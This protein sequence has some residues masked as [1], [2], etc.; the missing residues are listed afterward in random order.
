MTAAQTCTALTTHCI[1][2]IDEQY[3]RSMFFCLAEQVTHAAC[4]YA[5][6]HF[7]KVRTGY[8][9]EWYACLAG[10]RACKKRLTCSGRSYEQY[11]L[12]DLGPQFHEA[13]RVFQEFDYLGKLCLFF[14]GT[15]DIVKCD[16]VLFR[17]C[18]AGTALAETHD[19]LIAA[20]LLTHEEIPCTN[21]QY[22]SHYERYEFQPP[23][24]CCRSDYIDSERIIGR[25]YRIHILAQLFGIYRIDIGIECIRGRQLYINIVTRRECILG[26]LGAHK[27]RDQGIGLYGCL[28]YLAVFNHRKQFGIA[29]LI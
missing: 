10:N 19:A 13:I 28:R 6:E 5:D 7:D 18:H 8:D 3:R 26:Y 16:L 15:C 17:I 29:L 9:E 23:C 12:W 2:F 25:R 27:A 14:I 22:D 11:A 4:A 21:K 24:S 20:A 1:N